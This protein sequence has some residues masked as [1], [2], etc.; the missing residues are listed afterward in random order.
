MVLGVS[1]GVFAT[2]NSVIV[3]HV[4]TNKLIDPCKQIKYHIK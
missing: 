2:P 4:I 1:T 3:T